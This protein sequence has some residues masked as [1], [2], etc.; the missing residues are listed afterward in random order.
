MIPSAIRAA[1]SVAMMFVQHRN[2]LFGNC[3]KVS[4]SADAKPTAD[5]NVIRVNRAIPNVIL[6][7]RA[8]TTARLAEIATVL[9]G[10]I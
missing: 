5:R 3:S 4:K 7:I 6:A 9:A 2:S 1:K 8:A 10:D